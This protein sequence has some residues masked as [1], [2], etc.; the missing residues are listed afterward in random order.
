MGCPEITEA[1]ISASIPLGAAINSDFMN[2]EYESS[3]TFSTT[4]S[5]ETSDEPARAGPDSDVFVVPNLS[6]KYEEVYNV[7][8]DDT[9]CAFGVEKYLDP[10]GDE[11]VGFPISVVFDVKNTQDSALSFYTR[12]HLNT[13]ALPTLAKTIGNQEN[14]LKR[15]KAKEKIC[16]VQSSKKGACLHENT[17][18]FRNCGT[19]DIEYEQAKFDMLKAS[20]D[21]WQAALDKEKK[22]K[23]DAI[24]GKQDVSSWFNNSKE[25]ESV[26]ESEEDRKDLKISDHKAYLVPDALITSATALEGSKQYLDGADDKESIK[27]AMRV[28]IVGDG[29]K[30]FLY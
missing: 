7:R 1:D 6:I 9:E 10:N 29:G 4:W 16:C 23:A 17:E 3:H 2:E 19:D 26:V 13:V 11:K 18:V 15:V 28:H 21:G 12:Y 25:L 27:K 22:T 14:L 24:S 20:R 8:W 30:C 5:Y